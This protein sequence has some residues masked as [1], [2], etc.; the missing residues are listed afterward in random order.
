MWFDILVLVTF[1]SMVAQEIAKGSKVVSPT[2][3]MYAIGLAV[4]SFAVP[5][6]LDK[7]GIS[8]TSATYLIVFLI[9]L[10]ILFIVPSV[11]ANALIA[12]ALSGFL[13][14]VAVEFLPQFKPANSQLYPLFSKVAHATY[15]AV[16]PF[17]DKYLSLLKTK[18]ADLKHIDP[19]KVKPTL[20]GKGTG[21]EITPTL[22]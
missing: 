21:G 13:L 22:P 3:T 19:S 17:V 5:I 2:K 6:I 7:F 18:I 12:A 11:F 20:P 16:R 4:V 15:V 9:L 1:F 8:H 10:N 14:A